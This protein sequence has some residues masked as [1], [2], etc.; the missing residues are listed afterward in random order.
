MTSLQAEFRYGGSMGERQSSA[1]SSIRQVYGIWGLE[2][3]EKN[4]RIVIDYDASR[5]TLGTIG[6]LLR[7]AGIRV[8]SSA[9]TAANVQLPFK[10][11]KA[12]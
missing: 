9:P 1:L 4:R 11:R 12:A 8:Q 5:L 6:F 10:S 2:V 7:N 3:D